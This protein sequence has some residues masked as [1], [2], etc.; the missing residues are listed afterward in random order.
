VNQDCEKLKD[1][2]EIL[3]K[4]L[5]LAEKALEYYSWSGLYSNDQLLNYIDLRAREALE[6]LRK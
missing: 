5:R 4:K 1:H 3:E 2:I 6:E